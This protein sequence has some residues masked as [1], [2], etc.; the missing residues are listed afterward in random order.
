MSFRAAFAAIA[1]LPFCAV[2]PAAAI[3][4]PV[5]AT[6]FEAPV[7]KHDLDLTT[8]EGIAR[9]D[10]RV[11]TRVRQ[12]CSNGAL[13]SVSL[14]LE[15]ECRT[16]ALASTAPAIRVAIATAARDQLRLAQRTSSSPAVTPGA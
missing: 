12:M 4:A 3:A 5:N 16:S 7:A 1:A 15:R 11:R 2:A 9:L 14:R 10:D 13:D 8:R 6:V